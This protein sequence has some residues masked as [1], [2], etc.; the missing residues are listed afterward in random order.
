MNCIDFTKR[1]VNLDAVPLPPDVPR[2]L[3]RHLERE[4]DLVGE[5][6]PRNC[7]TT[8]KLCLL[9]VAISGDDG[10]PEAFIA[11]SSAGTSSRYLWRQNSPMSLQD[12]MPN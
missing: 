6:S 11:R 9:A 3:R 8:I 7:A 1:S 2:T 4:L 10:V 12:L 5:F